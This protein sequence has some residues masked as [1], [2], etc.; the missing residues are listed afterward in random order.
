MLIE[1]TYIKYYNREEI[2]FG[3]SDKREF[4]FYN[5]EGRG[6]FDEINDT[7]YKNIT[8]NKKFTRG[9]SS[10]IFFKLNESEEFRYFL[11]IDTAKFNLELLDIKT[12]EFSF[13]NLFEIIESNLFKEINNGYSWIQLL[14]LNNAKNKFLLSL[15]G[16]VFS[17]N[18]KQY[19]LC[20]IFL[21][22]GINSS[23]KKIDV[24]SIDYERSYFRDVKNANGNMIENTRFFVIQTKSGKLFYSLIIG[25]YKLYL[26][27]D[28]LMGNLKN[29]Y[30]ISNIVKNSFHKLILLKEELFLLCFYSNKYNPYN[31]FVDFYILKQE[32]NQNIVSTLHFNFGHDLYEGI[33]ISASDLILLNENKIAFVIQKW[34]GKKIS[35]YIFN[36]VDNYESVIILKFISN[37]YEQKLSY[38]ERN[39]IIFK[40]KELLGLHFE[41]IEGEHGF[42][43]FGYFN[44]TDPNQ[45][46]NLKKDGLNYVI[47]LD[48][49]LIL[50]SNIFE[51]QK[52]CVKI[53]EIPDFKQS[54]LYLISNVTK[55]ILQKDDCVDFNN[56]I[57]LN[58]ENKGV[59][60]KGKYF[61]K[62]CGVT[63]ELNL[64]E[65]DDYTDAFA[66]QTKDNK[67]NQNLIEEYNKNRNLNITGR[68][69]LIQINV[70]NDTKVYCDDKYNDTMIKIEKGKYLTCGNGKFYDVI[71]SN[72]IT[73]IDLGN[74]YYYDKYKDAYIKCHEKCKSCSK[75]YNETNMNCDECYDNYFL[76]NG[77]CLEISKCQNNYFYDF[78][79]KLK[80]ISQ[81]EYCPDFKPYENIKTKECIE[82]CDIKE[83]NSYLC[84]PTN[85]PIA[86]NET[87]NKILENFKYLN[88][89]KIKK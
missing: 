41:N 82:K 86:I 25:N 21:Y 10:S 6:L 40:Y 73:Q 78:D 74:K 88:L 38:I 15:Y 68:V 79:L 46:Y 59:I 76:R 1:L 63:E 75:E 70:L 84:V 80:C 43:L 36:F 39:A 31:N 19:E 2:A 50:Q 87:Y 89:E 45:I 9:F 23:K 30:I 58:F 72:E 52:K 62:F 60:K 85:N 17:Y 3:K 42:I 35:I 33:Y 65:I 83:I 69:A 8:L 12:G 44:S 32:E 13:D 5:E 18:T 57:S 26:M 24:Y 48:N 61:F 66:Y 7:F 64:E 22:F 16:Y 71:N 34:H 27:E 11:S 56:E 54:G 20:L 67:L 55:N 81:D 47:N 53:V 4:Y 14:K 28:D 77:I 29:F 51:Y 49:Y 37:I